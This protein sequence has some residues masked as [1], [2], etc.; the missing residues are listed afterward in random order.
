[1]GYFEDEIVAAVLGRNEVEQFGA[2]T[3]GALGIGQAFLNQAFGSF[4]QTDLGVTSLSLDASL[5]FFRDVSD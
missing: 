5:K 1:M 4:G 3:A 2:Q